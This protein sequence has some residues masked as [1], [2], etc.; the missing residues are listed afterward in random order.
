MW[1][2]GADERRVQRDFEGENRIIQDMTHDELYQRG[3]AALRAGDCER[4]I[5]HLESLL[6]EDAAE[7]SREQGLLGRYFLARAHHQLGLGH[8]GRRRFAEAASHFETAARLN[9]RGGGVARYLAACY[10]RTARPDRG[11]DQLERILAHDPDDAS[12]RIRLALARFQQSGPDE[13]VR[14]L[15]EGLER[16]PA[17]AELIY[18]LGV[19]Y[20]GCD[21]VARAR[22]CFEQ[23]IELEPA[24]AAAHERLAQCLAAA[25]D[26]QPAYEL[27][28]RAAELDPHNPRVCLQ[29]TVLAR[30][31]AATTDTP[32]APPKC[33]TQ[34]TTD[35]AAVEQLA[36]VI[37]QEPDFVTA[38]LSLP[39]SEADHEIFSALAATLER[40]LERHPEYAD[41]HYHCGQLYRRLGQDTAAIAHA[42][43]AVRI[44]P[45]YV[46]ALILLAELYAR[47]D[48][49]ADAVE[50]LEEAIRRGGDY[51]DVHDLLGHLHVKAGR[52]DRARA[53][54]ERALELNHNLASAKDALHALAA[55]NR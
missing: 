55:S 24:H 13:A 15:R 49:C 41:L 54:F 48:R 2:R 28:C 31:V 26:V 40:A 11:I 23:A 27:L 42:E 5:G 53:A 8:F 17:H 36:E 44:N 39:V 21:A 47:T 19:L 4:A 46:S 9:P 14:T 34:D 29:L 33:H 18:Q 20:A 6:A 30:A 35:R 25:G 7:V 10:F 37:A 50:R 32:L 45:R 51:A 22:K 16:Q 52:S 12:T 43:R 38:F 1:P 3:V